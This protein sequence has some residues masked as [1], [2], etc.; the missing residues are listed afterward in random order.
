M[1]SEIREKVIKFMESDENL[2]KLKDEKWYEVEDRLVALCE[3][4]SGKK[5]TTY[6]C[7]DIVRIQE[8]IEEWL[9]GIVSDREIRNFEDEVLELE[10]R[11]FG[12]ILEIVNKYFRTYNTDGEIDGLAMEIE[13]YFKGQGEQ[14]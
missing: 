11:D 12:N 6:D 13:E 14:I 3:K 8:I 9:G 2:S 10:D 1:I 7:K 5:D 4:V